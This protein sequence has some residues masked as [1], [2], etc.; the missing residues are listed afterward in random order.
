MKKLKKLERSLKKL[1]LQKE[2][3]TNIKDLTIFQFL[4]YKSIIS[5]ERNLTKEI[6]KVQSLANQIKFIYDAKTN[7]WINNSKIK[8]TK[9]HRMQQRAEYK[10]DLQLYKLGFLEEKPLSPLQKK[11]KPYLPKLNFS[12]K[13][14]FKKTSSQIHEFNSFKIQKELDRISI[15]IAKTAI[16]GYRKLHSGH[17]FVKNYITSKEAYRHMKEIISEAK[18]QVEQS[19]LQD[20]YAKS[21]LSQK[22][23]EFRKSLRFTPDSVFSAFGGAYRKQRYT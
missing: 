18:A 4:K 14:L 19:E 15:S 1:E 2:K 17:K 10:R 13:P 22:A 8:C 16:R 3:F 12:K 5:Q 23:V 7:S 9:Y 6:K 21:N 20:A 11:I